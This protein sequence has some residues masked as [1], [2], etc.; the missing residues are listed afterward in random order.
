MAI[1]GGVSGCYQRAAK[2]IIGRVVYMYD[3]IKGVNKGQLTH[4]VKSLDRSFSIRSNCAKS[5]DRS[6][7]PST[8]RR[9]LSC[10]SLTS[11]QAAIR[12]EGIN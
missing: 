10:F 7:D 2:A 8:G 9:N 5:S 12:W 1:E 11:S 6:G 4:L 3:T